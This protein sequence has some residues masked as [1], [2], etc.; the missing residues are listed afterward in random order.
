MPAT[1]S[2]QAMPC[3]H[4]SLLAIVSAVA[5]LMGLVP[6]RL[7][8]AQSGPVVVVRDGRGFSIT[9]DAVVDA[10]P[11]RVY[12]VLA[13]YAKLGALSPAIIAMSVKAAP[14]GRG[15]RVRSELKSCVWL[16]CR[17][18]VQVED[19]I[20]PDART[21]SARIVP[22]EGDFE[23]GW[24][25]WRVTAEGAGTRLHYEASRVPAFWIPPL[26]GPWAIERTL[27]AQLESSI[28]VLE[29]LANP[30]AR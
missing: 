17:K 13:D 26:I 27:R 18:I 30:R 23:S 16:F 28:P 4:P 12:E 19:V 9:F 22:G 10:P 11:Q 1:C 21:I 25:F 6:T 20:E 29:R 5:L 14:G 7:L 24:C 3:R 8:A 2:V 15:E